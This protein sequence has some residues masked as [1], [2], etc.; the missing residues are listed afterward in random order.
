MQNKSLEQN[1]IANF[2]CRAPMISNLLEDSNWFA[3]NGWIILGLLSKTMKIKV[4]SAKVDFH[5]QIIILGPVW[6][7]LASKD[8]MINDWHKI[9]IN[10]GFV[11]HNLDVYRQIDPL[12]SIVVSISINPAF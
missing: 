4:Y 2:V 10:Y 3:Q 9:F 5:K 11:T 8:G 6:N 7:V 1:V 12:K